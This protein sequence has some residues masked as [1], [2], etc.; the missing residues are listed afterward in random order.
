MGSL[1]RKNNFILLAAV[2]AM[3]WTGLFS[4]PAFA[5]TS[6]EKRK[7]QLLELL[8]LDT[9]DTAVIRTAREAQRPAR[10]RLVSLQEGQEKARR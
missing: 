9:S 1:A 3:I 7:M 6:V 4:S 10:I 8:G 5:A 2:L